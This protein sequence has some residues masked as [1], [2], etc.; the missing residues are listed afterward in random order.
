MTPSRRIFL[1]WLAGAPLLV[2]G[3]DAK[4]HN[5]SRIARLIEEARTYPDV[6]R[7]IDFISRALLGMRYR[8][9]TLIGGP[10]RPEVFVVR[11]DAFDCVTY[12]ETVL[13]AA[14]AKDLREF[15]GILL[16]IRYEH[17]KVRWDER[18]HYFADWNDR[19]VEK[20][21][22]RPVEMSPSV[23]IEKTVDGELGPRKV[24]ITGIAPSTLMANR[25][26]LR[27]GDVIGFVSRRSRLD[28]FHAGF[29]AFAKKGTLLLR[30]A[31][32]SHGR[33]VDED[34]QAFLAAN[35]V[36]YVTLL[37]AEDQMTANG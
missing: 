12:C 8:A 15:E 27:N 1:Q 7:R 34:M 19:I 36:R 17:G 6:S 18:N 13:A 3:V 37:R 20:H 11:D 32:Q 35:G 31:S 22:C 21:I 14:L 10:R 2:F 25:Q 24:S 28:F 23:A 4:A 30:H 16:R 33:V 9:D 5:A 26:L 29:I